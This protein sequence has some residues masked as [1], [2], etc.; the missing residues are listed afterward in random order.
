MQES[1]HAFDLPVPGLPNPTPSLGLQRAIVNAAHKHNM[2]TVA[3]AFS[4]RD[5]LQVLEA[6]VDGLVH[7]CSEAPSQELVDAFTRIRAFVVPTLVAVASVS[8]EEQES[9][10]K[11]ARR[12]EQDERDHMCGCLKIGRPGFST[13]NAIETVKALKT[14]G[15][16]IVW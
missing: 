10:E 11:F 1:G 7:A 16:E 9:R 3:H 2:L 8:G 4:T 13:E 6:G 14:A 5:T 12:L 15:T